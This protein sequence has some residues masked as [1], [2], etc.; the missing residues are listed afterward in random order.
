MMIIF[1]IYLIRASTLG[2]QDHKCQTD[3][4]YARI[5]LPNIFAKQSVGEGSLPRISYYNLGKIYLGMTL[6]DV[7]RKLGEPYCQETYTGYNSENV[8]T[9]FYDSLKIVTVAYSNN[10]RQS[11]SHVYTSSRILQ[12]AEGIRCGMTLF[13]LKKL[14]PDLT[15]K[16]PDSEHY[17]GY[18]Y[19][20]RSGPP[21]TVELLIIDGIVQRLE[22][23]DGSG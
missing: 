21:P 10:D 16:L 8:T 7:Y 2:G 19:I 9:L 18:I 6:E 5:G 13:D 14:V 12:T 1:L 3:S 23:G 22:I 17:I 15:L 11:V 4:V 20:S